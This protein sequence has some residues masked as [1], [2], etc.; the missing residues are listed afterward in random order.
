VAV[1]V[2]AREPVDQQVVQAAE[3]VVV[4]K[5]ELAEQ[6]HLVKA[7]VVETT[8][9]TILLVAVQVVAQAVQAVMAQ[10]LQLV[11]V[12]QEHHHQLLDHL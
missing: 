1:A 6:V 3:L 8:T 9:P 10:V 11:Q 5:Q 7:I 4:I 2:H 12:A